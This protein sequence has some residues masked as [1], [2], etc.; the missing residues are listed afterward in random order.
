LQP[1]AGLNNMQTKIQIEN[2]QKVHSPKVQRCSTK[3]SQTNIKLTLWSKT[4]TFPN[5]FSTPECVKAHWQ[6]SRISK[7]STGLPT[8]GKNGKGR[9]NRIRDGERETEMVRGWR[10]GRKGER[11]RGR[12]G[13]KGWGGR[14]SPKQAFTT[15]PCLRPVRA[16]SHRQSYGGWQTGTWEHGSHA[17][18]C[19]PWR[20]DITL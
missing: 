2:I 7:F 17:L 3:C 20:P 15:T 19:R 9:G 10:R 8:F 12:K 4:W 1:N 5:H 14:R 6:Q 18:A 16:S 13:K 11:D